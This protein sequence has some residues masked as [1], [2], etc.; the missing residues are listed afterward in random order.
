MAESNTINIKNDSSDFDVI[1]KI[2]N[3]E[4]DLYELLMRRNNQR[5]YRVIR[6]YITIEDDILDV[7]QNSYL[8][9]Y[10]NL[11]KFRKEASFNTWLIRIG[12]NE[13]LARLNKEQKHLKD[14]FG[15]ETIKIISISEKVKSNP[16][17]IMIENETK[18]LL[19]RAI[20]EL[21]P[22]YKIPYILKEIEGLSIEEIADSIGISESNV[23]VRIHRAKSQLKDS[24]FSYTNSMEVF[25]FG[26]SKCDCLVSSIMG[27]IV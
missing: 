3:G 4:K 15:P 5:L 2:I 25:E 7:M 19:E 8:K 21:A 10:E 6:G 24:L 26:S 16:E 18:E 23:K 12:I 9:A 20:L 22:N 11:H 13:A 27:R 1:Q 17:N 14:S